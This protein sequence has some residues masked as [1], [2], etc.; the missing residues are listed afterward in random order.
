MVLLRA[1]FLFYIFFG[2]QNLWYLWCRPFSNCF[3]DKKQNNVGNDFK[4]AGLLN[5]FGSLVM[6]FFGLFSI[7]TW[8]KNLVRL[9]SAGLTNK[10]ARCFDLNLLKKVTSNVGLLLLINYLKKKKK[11]KFF[12]NATKNASSFIYLYILLHISHCISSLKYFDALHE[13]GSNI[14]QTNRLRK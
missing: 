13:I 10:Q 12:D 7:F 9:F 5:F 3:C 4:K 14:C 6:N 8:K 2:P 1:K 11:H